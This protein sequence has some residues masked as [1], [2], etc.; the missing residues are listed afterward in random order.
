ML[1][2]TQ[3]KFLKGV[4]EKRAE[5]FNSLGVTTIN[6]LF[7]YYPRA[8]EDWSS[9]VLIKD[10]EWLDCCCIKATVAGDVRRHK[11]KSNGIMVFET[12][13][14]DDTGALHIVIFNN[15]YAAMK[16][17]KGEELLFFGTVTKNNGVLQMLSPS[18]EK[19]GTKE[20]I[21]PIY[22]RSGSMTSNYI[23]K[24]VDT[25]IKQYGIGIEDSLPQ[26]IIEKYDLMPLDVAIREIHFPS[27]MEQMTKAR[28]RFLFEELFLLQL[29]LKIKKG[30]N[31]QETDVVASVDC[32]DDFISRL[33]FEPTAAQLKCI[34]AGVSDMAS[35]FAMNRLLQGDVG[36]GKTMV[37]AALMYNVYANGYQ[38]VMMA[39][40]EILAKQHGETLAKFFEGTAVKVAT[41]TGGTPAAE[42]REI[43]AGLASGEIA[44]AVG[45]HALISD[46]VEFRNLGFVIT[47]EQHRFGVRQRA[48][49]KEKGHGV[50]VLVMSA[51]PIPRTLAW[52]AYGDLD[53]S[54]IDE[55]PKGRVPIETYKINSS[56]RKRA[57]SYIKKHL[58]EGRQGYIVCPLVEEGEIEGV[59]SAKEYFDLIKDGEFKDYSVGLLHGQMKAQEKASVMERFQSGEIQL[60]VSTV[61]IEVGVDVPNAVIMLIENAERFGLSQLHQ[62]RGRVGRG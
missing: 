12:D 24:C 48:K 49:L 57:F 56:I 58:D 30:E 44:I 36:S 62:L 26:D 18:I 21:R 46:N 15:K 43:L 37:A 54:V 61:V 28:H 38:S 50:H 9:P 14:F 1:L 23:E 39:P 41:L 34:K 60:L 40:T 16:L 11:A 59:L 17:Q 33:P 8:Y 19:T 22:K 3:I 31:K 55:L 25:A 53:V 2:D 13:V 4:G 45:T 47:D 51:T 42:K 35:G 20:R 6:A 29:G 5:Q 32:T 7:H 10:S 27:S 52:A